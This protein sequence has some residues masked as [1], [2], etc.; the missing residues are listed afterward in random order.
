MRDFVK[1]FASWLP[2]AL[3]AQLGLIGNLARVERR[4][5]FIEIDVLITLGCTSAECSS[6]MRG[7]SAHESEQVTR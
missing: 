6:Y 5:L 4:L 3:V 7:G 1:Q 2:A